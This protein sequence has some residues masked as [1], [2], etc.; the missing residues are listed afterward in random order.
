MET[1]IASDVE[2][3][4]FFAE[5]YHNGEQWC[6]IYMDTDKN[7]GVLRI[8]ADVDVTMPLSEALAAMHKAYERLQSG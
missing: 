6:E 2:R 8:F 5:L 3:D 1:I 4:E 7:E